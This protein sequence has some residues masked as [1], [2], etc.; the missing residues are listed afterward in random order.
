M[1][2]LLGDNNRVFV[3]GEAKT[4]CVK[5][6]IIDLIEHASRSGKPVDESRIVLLANMTSP[7]PNVPDDIEDIVLAKGYSVFNP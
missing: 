4:H 1:D 7:I 6:S 3:C 2:Q 5:S